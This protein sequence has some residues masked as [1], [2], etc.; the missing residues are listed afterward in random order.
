MKMK[1]CKRLIDFVQIINAEGEVRLCSWSLNNIVGNLQEEDITTILRG[2]KAKE[3]RRK[4][5]AGDFSNCPAD[6]CPYIANGNINEILVEYDENKIGYPET[7]LLAYEGNC[8]YNCTCCTSHQHMVDTRMN[9]YSFL[10]DSLEERIKTILPYIKH[11]GANGRGEVFV[12]PRTMRLLSE[13]KPN[14]PAKECSV[15]IE[16]NGSL[17]NENNWKKID[18]L[19]KYHLKVAITVMSFDELTY[20]YLSGT[21]Y[22]IEKLLE[23]LNFVKKLREEGIID[24]LEIATVMQELNFREMPE[25]TRRCLEEFGADRV[26]I[27]PIFPGGTLD[28]NMQWFADVRNNC[29]PY[30]IIYQ[31]IME[32]EIFKDERVLLWSGGLDSGK[33][34][35]PKEK[36]HSLLNA[37]I[38]IL[39]SDNLINEEEKTVVYG[40][41]VVGKT[42]VQVYRER[43]EFVIDQYNGQKIYKGVPIVKLDKADLA[44]IDCIIVAVYREFDA[45]R[46]VLLDRG[47][48]G[49]IIN[50][51]GS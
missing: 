1:T 42:I 40:L 4:I 7:L 19:G 51:Y 20:Q 6:N 2:E 15:G 41:G 23:S 32:D 29:H 49:R 3:L 24:E 28:K 26:R 39:N 36:E 22:P 16:T 21:N 43:I 44:E 17:F 27:R 48:D 18:N 25:F 5:A 34:E 45:I 37:I 9:D 13:W 8:N 33:G 11:I 14:A 12:S 35:L 10:Y 47:Y 31:R 46:K 30:N 50:I 38:S